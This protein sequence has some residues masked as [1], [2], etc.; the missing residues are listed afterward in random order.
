[1]TE[2]IF[3]TYQR[4]GGYVW[5]SIVRDLRYHQKVANYFFRSKRPMIPQSFWT[6]YTFI[7]IKIGI[8]E[9]SRAVIDLMEIIL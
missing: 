7:A 2:V 5:C 4:L 6:L 1:M 3:H 9:L 8:N